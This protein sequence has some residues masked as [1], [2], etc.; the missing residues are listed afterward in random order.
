MPTTEQI[1]KVNDVE[2]C[3]QSLGDPADPAIQCSRE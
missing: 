3:V 1:I 2:L